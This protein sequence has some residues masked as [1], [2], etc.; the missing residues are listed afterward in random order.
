M[1]QEYLSPQQTAQLLGLSESTIKRLRKNADEIPWTRVGHQIR[2]HIHDVRDWMRVNQNRHK[3]NVD[4][5]AT[6]CPEETH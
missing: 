6:S 4:N 5:T 3:R 1:Q 2:Y